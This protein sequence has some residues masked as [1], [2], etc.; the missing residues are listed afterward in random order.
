MKSEDKVLVSIVIGNYNYDCFIKE[1]IDSALNQTYH[2][3]EVIV[4][5]DGSNDR[6]RDI[7]ASY[8]NK[9]ITK[10]KEN[11]GQPSNFNLGFASS[12]GDIVCF[13]D[14][15]DI[16]LPTKVEE[17]VKI[18]VVYKE[19]DWC[20]HS[21]QL[22]DEI[23]KPL[24]MT[25][26]VNYVTRK[27]DFRARLKSGRIPPSFPSTSA[28]SF[29]RSLLEKILPMPTTKLMPGSDHYLKYMASALGQ[30]FILAKDLTLQRIHKNNMGTLRKDRYHMQA[31]ENLLTGL[32]VKQE[33][34]E[35]SNFSYKLVGVGMKINWQCG[36]KDFDN[37]K[38]ILQ[39]MNSISFIERL[40]VHSIALYYSLKQLIA[41]MKSK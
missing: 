27:C 22:I 16:F 8:G 13:L 24:N 35:F 23:G 18:F 15:D 41:Y 40:W 38:I 7:I 4:I 17:I 32:W 39:Y 25:T 31:R 26:T 29:R 3:V 5:D 19:I 21:L 9:V 2:N 6:S 30:G 20:F 1:A 11:G 10:F 36:N 14:S 12:R 37:N 33:F 28:L 34:P